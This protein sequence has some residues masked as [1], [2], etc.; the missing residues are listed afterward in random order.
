MLLGGSSDSSV[1]AH[2]STVTQI[3]RDATTYSGQF[4]SCH[5]YTQG[6]GRKTRSRGDG[7]A[8]SDLVHARDRRVDAM[9]PVKQHCVRANALVDCWT[10]SCL[11]RRLPISSDAVTD[12]GA[13]RRSS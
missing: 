9:I 8:H 13:H 10:R 6:A 3:E 1:R 5:E 12:V 4:A 2:L 7:L 11:N